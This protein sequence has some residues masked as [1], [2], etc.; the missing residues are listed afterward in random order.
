M[1]MHW[2]ISFS[3]EESGKTKE[4]ISFQTNNFEWGNK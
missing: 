3:G 2:K 4:E 1:R